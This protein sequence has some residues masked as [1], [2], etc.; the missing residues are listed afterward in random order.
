MAC[1]T[2]RL[3]GHFVFYTFYYGNLIEIINIVNKNIFKV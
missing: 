1:F 2:L 3:P